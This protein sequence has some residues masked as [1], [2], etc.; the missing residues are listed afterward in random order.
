VAYYF[1]SFKSRFGFALFMFLCF[2][3][4]CY[5]HGIYTEAAAIIASPYVIGALLR[6]CGGVKEKKNVH[7]VI[8]YG[9]FLLLILSRF[10]GIFL[11]ALLPLYTLIANYNKL[12]TKRVIKNLAIQ[13]CCIFLI[14]GISQSITYVI[15]KYNKGDNMSLYGR[16]GIY[17]VCD[18]LDTACTNSNPI[19]AMS[20]YQLQA[21]DTLTK[22]IFPLFTTRSQLWAGVHHQVDS[23]RNE[24]IA[25]GLIG[26]RKTTDDYLNKAFRIYLVNPPYYPYKCMQS[27]FV[28]M[29]T[30]SVIPYCINN[31]LTAMLDDCMA[32]QPLL[33]K[34]RVY[35]LSHDPGP[36]YLST[37]YNFVLKW[38][39][40]FSSIVLVFIMGGALFF[41]RK[42]LP[43]TIK[44]LS[45]SVVITSLFF[46]VATLIITMQLIRY[47]QPAEF[48]LYITTAIILVYT[49]KRDSSFQEQI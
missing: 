29:V 45:V 48:I 49:Q 47:V 42:K 11:L 14:L 10:A 35:F 43:F 34:A 3:S 32:S 30:A 44:L 25:K 24:F 2:R 21:N 7:Q 1:K 26:D 31:S 15:V 39:D 13:L 18:A 9:A 19:L 37:K 28:A 46:C 4:T 41:R 36:A 8:Y 12:F 5:V 23:L 38:S 17:R 33:T 40:F 16:P 27:E 22:R 6:I 20:T